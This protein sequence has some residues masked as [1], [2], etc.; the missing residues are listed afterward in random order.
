MS[1]SSTRP[2]E[3]PAAAPAKKI[4][5]MLEI[6]FDGNIKEQ[7]FGRKIST[8]LETYSK[9]NSPESGLFESSNN[10]FFKRRVDAKSFDI[11]EFFHSN[12]FARIYI[13]FSFAVTKKHASAQESY[14]I[15]RSSSERPEGSTYQI[16]AV[17]FSREQWLEN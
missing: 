2:A 13:E 14:G 4:L 7:H 8:R 6:D 16:N 15:S 17:K 10:C 3:N 9:T 11:L 1:L 12:L 5:V